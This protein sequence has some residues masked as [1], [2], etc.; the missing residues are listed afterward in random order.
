MQKLHVFLVATQW[1]CR[2]Y[3]GSSKIWQNLLCYHICII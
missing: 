3:N 2:N 1:I